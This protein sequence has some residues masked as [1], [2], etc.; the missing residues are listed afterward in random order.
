MNRVFNVSELNARIKDRLT[1]DLRLNDLWA[2]GELSDVVNHRSGHR[3]FTL[4]DETSQISCVLFRNKGKNLDFELENGL[5]VLVFGDVSFYQV[6]GHVQIIARAIEKDSGLGSRH[7]EFE[8]LKKKLMAE[9]LFD[10]ARKRQLP[11]Y[12]SKIGIITSPDGAALQDVLRILGSYPAGII[13]SPAQVQGES[14]PQSIALALRALRGKA[15]VAIVCRGGGS[16][17]D[18]WPFNSEVVARTIY[19]SDC[20]IVSAVGHETDIT[21]ADFVADVRA[22]TP[23]AAA[24][25][26]K[27]D[28]A[29]L[30]DTLQE[31]EVRMTRSLSTTLERRQNKLSRIEMSLSA[32]TMMRRLEEK[33]CHLERLSKRI[34]SAETDKTALLKTRLDL[35][36][37]KLDE[38]SPLATLTRGYA[39]VR[40]ERGLV[41]RSS[42]V[43]LG[44]EI[45]LILAEGR[46]RCK[47]TGRDLRGMN[48][49]GE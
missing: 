35:A 33:R 8:K 25:I 43:E 27:P 29:G 24:E 45:D 20:P 6:R 49:G 15:D 48:H 10:E 7:Q 5:N 32:S 26:V 12:P 2:S 36:Q 46:L 17:E 16:T 13:L 31:W 44:E 18:L 37:G 14:A 34:L 30:E 19:Q 1:T 28:I 9:G 41:R 23:S 40:T 11:A 39:I 21:I 38:L 42:N 47:V 3:Y 4:K 22:P